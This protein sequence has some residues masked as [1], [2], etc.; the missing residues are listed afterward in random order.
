LASKDQVTPLIIAAAETAPAE[1]SMFL[2]TS[3]R[4]IDV[5]KTLIQRGAD[6]NPKDKVE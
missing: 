3:T 2:P 1:G 5:A 6:V 4:P